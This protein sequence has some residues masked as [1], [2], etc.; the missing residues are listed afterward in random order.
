[1]AIVKLAADG[2]ELQLDDS[3][4]GDDTRLKQALSPFYPE[5]ATASVRR[6]TNGAGQMVVSLVKQAGT[7]GL[8]GEGADT[9]PLPDILAHLEA[10]PA[11]VNPALEMAWQ[12]QFRQATGTLTVE[13][14]LALQPKIEAAGKAGF[15]E[16]QHIS[17]A[18]RLL[19]T[20]TAFQPVERLT[21][22]TRQLLIGF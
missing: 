3:I 22:A 16:E 14:V 9:D 20:E 11:R 13:D 21:D 8:V 19:M 7:K 5:I 2:Q 17:S 1:M 15:E 4:A 6:E 10:L 12:I 18:S